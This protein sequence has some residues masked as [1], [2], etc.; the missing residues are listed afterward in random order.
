MPDPEQSNALSACDRT[1]CWV[2]YGADSGYL[3][4]SISKP[5]LNFFDCCSAVSGRSY[6]DTTP[7]VL[8]EFWPDVK[9]GH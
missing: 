8:F 9:F 7:T 2:A 4:Q 6:D 5:S 3:R 1:F